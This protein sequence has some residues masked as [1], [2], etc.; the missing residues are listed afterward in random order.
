MK[1]LVIIFSLIFSQ[2]SFA[3]ALVCKDEANKVIRIMA[4]YNFYGSGAVKFAKPCAD[5]I[6]NSYNQNFK[7]RLNNV[8]DWYKL[9]VEIQHKTISEKDVFENQVH[10]NL[11]PHVNYARIGSPVKELIDISEHD[12]HG[13]HGYFRIEDNLGISKTC[14]HEFGH[15]LGLQHP[16]HWLK[17]SSCDIRGSGVPGIMTPRGCLVDKKYQYDPKKPAG[18]KGGTINPALREVR[19][20]EITSLN[21]GDLDFIQVS[22]SISCA[23]L[24]NED[25][26]FYFE[27]GYKP[28]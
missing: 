10:R 3:S 20:Y 12:L 5:E 26:G 14:A 17:K 23:T 9:N 11:K 13:N 4:I 27:N 28:F 19:D 16:N 22:N 1:N 7:I 24:G 18:A 2:F 21:L 25:I 15:G 6:K 8:G